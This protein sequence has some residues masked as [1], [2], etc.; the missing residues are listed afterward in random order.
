MS[1]T[2]WLVV[3]LGNPGKE[4]AG[5]RH[6]VGYQVIDVLAER[7]A[8]RFSKHRRANADVAEGRLDGHRIALLR[9]RTY[10]NE[11]GGPIRAAADYAQIPLTNVIVV[12]DELD[13]EFGAI[14]IKVGGGDGGHN[15]I[16]SAKKS[17]G[18]P[19]FYRVRVGIGRPPGRQDAADYVLRSFSA[20]QRKNLPD[21]LESGADAVEAI[22][23]EG[24]AVAQNRH[25][26]K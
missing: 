4:Y 12:H 23:T 20:D 2:P 3:G 25:H 7:I 22:I 17:L 15:G 21:V 14:K 13:I 16:K 26:S 19:D 5:T 10:M 6:N 1:Q 18:S 9:S 8:A 24:L 11:S